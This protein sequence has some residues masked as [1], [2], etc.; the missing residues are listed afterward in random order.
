MDEQGLENSKAR[1]H[2]QMMALATL[3]HSYQSHGKEVVVLGNFE[4]ASGK[5]ATSAATREAVADESRLGLSDLALT[6]SARDDESVDSAGPAIQERIFIPA[7]VD[8]ELY[9]PQ[10]HA[11]ANAPVGASATTPAG[12]S[13]YDGQL[14]TISLPIK[15]LSAMESRFNGSFGEQAV[16]STSQPQMYGL[17]NAECPE[18]F[19]E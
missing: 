16:G 13:R 18:R 11:L 6:L 5:D 12:A 8:A 19:G 3:V 14:A 17:S 9:Q 10:M 15:R 4:T 1:R 7:G 2:Q